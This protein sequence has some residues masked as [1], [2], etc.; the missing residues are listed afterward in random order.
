[1]NRMLP[2]RLSI[3]LIYPFNTNKVKKATALP[4]PL[5]EVHE[6]LKTHAEFWDEKLN[7]L[8]SFAENNDQ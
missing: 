5:I 6:W 1:M 7:N 8:K 3:P 2:N 4:E